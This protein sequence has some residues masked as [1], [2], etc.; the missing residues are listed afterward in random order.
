MAVASA[1]FLFLVFFRG[2][3]FIFPFTSGSNGVFFDEAQRVLAGEVMY[4]D[5]FEF[6]GPGNPYLNALVLRFTGPHI[7]ALGLLAV[8]LGTACALLVHHLAASVVPGRWR[9]LAPA[10]FA[11]LVFAPY[12]FGDHKWPAL[13]CGLGGLAALASGSAS[14]ARAMAA[15]ALLGTSLLFTQDLGAGLFAGTFVFVLLR[16]RRLALPFVAAFVVPPLLGFGFFV[17]RAGLERVFYDGLLFPLTHYRDLNRFALTARPTWRTLPREAAQVVLAVAGVLGALA[18]LW[19]ERRAPPDTA[20]LLALAGLGMLLATGHR[21]L[22]PMGLA[23]QTAVLIP[24]ALRT[25][26]S[27]AGRGRVAARALLALVALG[28]AHGLFGFV[29][30]RQLMQPM[31]KEVHRAGTVWTARAMPELT[32][33]ESQT[34]PGEAAFLLPARGGHYFL[35]RTRDVT[36]FPYLI[37]GQSTP[38]QARAALGQIEAARPRVGL[39]DQR[40]WPRGT[41]ESDGPLAFLFQELH[42]HYDFERLPSGVYLLRRKQP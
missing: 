22:Y 1:L 28:V 31:V 38:E 39:W 11:V 3:V 36:G 27:G 41:P 20:R 32:W 25:L 17:A 8:A 33:I 16:E 30:W 4:R 12:T 13:L 6:V 9:L 34:A 37:E 26:L 5:F 21:G 42:V 18:A 7:A 14:R 35:T 24:L 40:P 15:G 19:R 29:V 10:A 2:T 23:V